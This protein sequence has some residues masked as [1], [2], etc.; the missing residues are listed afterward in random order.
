[1]PPDCT[2]PR[3]SMKSWASHTRKFRTSPGPVE[4]W[5]NQ[6]RHIMAFKL[7]TTDQV[8]ALGAEMGMEITDKYAQSFLNYIAPFAEGYRAIAA[9]PDDLPPVKYP[10][11]KGYRPEGAENKYG[12]WAVKAHIKGA[13]SG[14]LA[15]KKIAIKDTYAVAGLP[16]TN[17]A[18][19]LEGYVPEFDA[20][21]VTRLLDA[22]AEVIG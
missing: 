1:M 5:D 16:L 20:S 7:P 8:R 6:G 13:K 22:G 3:S 12:A 10:R 19:V 9:L 11:G 14:K 17:G 15:G 4:G 21:V 18:S 2:M